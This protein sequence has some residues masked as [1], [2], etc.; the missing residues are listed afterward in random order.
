MLAR[1]AAWSILK[2]RAPPKEGK[3]EKLDLRKSLKDLYA[4]KPAPA[5]VEAP[6][7]ACFMIDGAGDP[8]G[9]P[10]FAAA[11]EALY[12][13]SYG[14]K[15]AH[16]KAGK[17]DWTV[18]GLE[19]LWW[20][21]DMAD[22]TAGNKSGW[23]WT[24]LIVQPDFVAEADLTA[25][26]EEAAKKK[27]NPALGKLRFSRFKEGLSA[28]YLHTGSYAAEGPGIARLHDF[29]REN[30][31]ELSGLHHEIYLS[32]ARRVPEEKLKTIIRQP[33]R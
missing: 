12:S 29:I 15:F 3:M 18:M 21:E 24:L 1:T 25:A 33:C 17:A 30:G 11:V 7:L 32:D 2:G 10:E 22:F 20:S 16:K 26:V 8:N 4:A 28:Q 13:V 19:G 27:G 9:S 14:L 6:E 5:F 23:K 31:K